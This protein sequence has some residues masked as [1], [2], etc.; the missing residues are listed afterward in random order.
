MRVVAV[1]GGN[2]EGQRNVKDSS[3][4]TEGG[5]P[6]IMVVVVRWRT[7]PWCPRYDSVDL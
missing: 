6:S 4:I 5:H 2:G 7:C 3:S 1:V